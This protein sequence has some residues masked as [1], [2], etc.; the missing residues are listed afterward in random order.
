MPV[1]DE[2]AL[3]QAIIDKFNIEGYEY[4]SGD[5]LHRELTAVLIEDDLR[6]FLSIK[7]ADK[8]IT[9][10]EINSIVNSIKLVSN[11]PL[12]SSN[13]KMFLRMVEGENFVREDRNSKDFFLQLIDFDKDNNRNII[14]IVNQL[15]IKSSTST[16]R[17]DAIVYVNGLPLVVM[18]F[19]SAVKEDTTIHDAYI[20]IT[21]RYLRDIPELFK[22]N[23][24]AVISDGVNTKVGSIFADYEHFF[25]WR[26]KEGDERPADGIDSLDTM[27]QGL[28]MILSTSLIL[29]MVR[30]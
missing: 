15:T 13:K 3:E 23:C 5:N 24:F 12:Y 14:K 20:Q 4:V 22:Y 21:T 17:P 30:I 10:N 28:Y 9:D 8:M 2:A 25:S 26:R 29:I 7:Y 16:R 11:Q 19:K 18:E 1:F 6:K 27:I